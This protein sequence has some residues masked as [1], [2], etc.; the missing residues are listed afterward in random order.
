MSAALATWAT[1]VLVVATML[2]A[3]VLIATGHG[4]DV[5]TIASL[6]VPTIAVLGLAIRSERQ[7]VTTIAK[8]EQ[9][10]DS[11]NGAAA[12][13]ADAAATTIAERDATIAAQADELDRRP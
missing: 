9:V 7:H 3:V 6:S 11:V 12:V 8:V 1:V 10:Q 2:A 4:D 13:L 5:Q